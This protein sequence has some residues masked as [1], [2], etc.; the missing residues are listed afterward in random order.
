MVGGLCIL[1]SI[2]GGIGYSGDGEQSVGVPP[3][4]E[5]NILVEGSCNVG[6]NS[7]DIPVPDSFDFISV[8]INVE[9]SLSENTWVGVV[10][11][12]YAEKCPPEESGLT[13]CSKD[14]FEYIAGGPDTEGSFEWSMEP[15][16][17]RFVT[18]SESGTN[19][20]DEND[21]DFTYQIGMKVTYIIILVLLGGGLVAFGLIL[22]PK[23]KVMNAIPLN[24]VERNLED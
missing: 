19:P 9:W 24:E 23:E 22:N 14:E 17:Y 21:V 13:D 10:D 11:S 12:S 16:S 1:I 4:I 5:G 7:D 8:K 2:I 6:M 18:G 15:G 20:V 3:C